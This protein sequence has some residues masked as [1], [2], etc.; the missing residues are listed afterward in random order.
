MAYDEVRRLELDRTGSTG[1]G[2][3]KIEHYKIVAHA[4]NARKVTIAEDLDG[5]EL[6][7]QFMGYLAS[8]MGVESGA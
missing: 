8:R 1:Q 7:R 4:S 6:A 5:E 2:V 3:E